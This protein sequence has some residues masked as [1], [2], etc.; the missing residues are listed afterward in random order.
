MN[1]HKNNN[2]NMYVTLIKCCEENQTRTKRFLITVVS[3]VVEV[4]N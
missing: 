1:I 3:E 4:W 2:K